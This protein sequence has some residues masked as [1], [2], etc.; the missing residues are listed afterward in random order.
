MKNLFRELGRCIYNIVVF[1]RRPVFG[2]GDYINSGRERIAFGE[3]MNGANSRRGGN[4]EERRIAEKLSYAIHLG[5]KFLDDYLE[6]EKDLVK[7]IVK[8]EEK[9]ERILNYESRIVEKD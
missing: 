8:N 1:Y 9:T 2:V 7:T 5:R 6:W 4:A 3:R